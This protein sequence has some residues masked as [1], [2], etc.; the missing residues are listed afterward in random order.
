[1]RGFSGAKTPYLQCLWPQFWLEYLA[2]LI[3]SVHAWLAMRTGNIR[4]IKPSGVWTASITLGAKPGE[5]LP[6]S[7]SAGGIGSTVLQFARRRGITLIGTATTQNHDYLRGLGAIP[8]R[9]GPG[10]AECVR[11]L[12][13]E[14]VDATLD[15]TGSGIIPEMTEIVG[16]PSRVRSVA[17]FSALQYRE[18]FSCELPKKSEAGLGPYSSALFMG[19]F[20]VCA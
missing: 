12:T 4:G 15:L 8:T 20:S 1:L 18:M 19:A 7:G 16:D 11:K 2:L 6:E 9:C 13:P 17:V 3:S 5:T 14:G 10:L